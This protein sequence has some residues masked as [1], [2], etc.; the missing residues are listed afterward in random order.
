M[1]ITERQ[2]D[3]QQRAYLRRAVNKMNDVIG[4]MHPEGDP[5]NVRFRDDT[6][7][8]GGN[9]ETPLGSPN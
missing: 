9:Y 7:Q 4:G 5:E 6:E 2:Q 1:E 8:H 3:Q